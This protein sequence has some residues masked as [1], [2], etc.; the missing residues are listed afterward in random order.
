[1]IPR[2]G[3]KENWSGSCKTFK[4][5]STHIFRKVSSLPS[6]F[7]YINSLKINILPPPPKNISVHL[8]Y[9]FVFLIL[10]T[11]FNQKTGDK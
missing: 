3:K 6:S 9:W 11:K 4:D 8:T 2:N 10:Y 1:M 5:L 7:L